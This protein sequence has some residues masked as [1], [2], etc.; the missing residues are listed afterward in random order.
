[1]I[2]LIFLVF[3]VFLLLL[4]RIIIIRHWLSGETVGVVEGPLNGSIIGLALAFDP[5]LKS[6]H[7]QVSRIEGFMSWSS[8]IA[9]K[10]EEC[11]RLHLMFQILASTTRDI[12]PSPPSDLELHLGCE[13]ANA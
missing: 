2:F 12:S 5:L 1:M 10:Q 13:N 9:V 11:R 4:L 8:S 3:L 6:G 7:L